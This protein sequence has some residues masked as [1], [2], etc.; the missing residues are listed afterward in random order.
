MWQTEHEGDVLLG[1]AAAGGVHVNSQSNKDD[2]E[3]GGRPI[4]VGKGP[5]LTTAPNN[6][7]KPADVVGA[8]YALEH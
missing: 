2:R 4:A 6:L 1:Q 8:K 7:L 5:D 3:G